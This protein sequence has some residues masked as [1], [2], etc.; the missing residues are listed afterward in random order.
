MAKTRNPLGH[1]SADRVLAY[2]MERS[3]RVLQ[4]CDLLEAL[5]DDLPKRSIPMWR[6]TKKQCALA[7]SSHFAL[8]VGVV[9]PMLLER[10]DGVADREDVILRVKADCTDL[11]HR[12]S[13]LEELFSDALS[14]STYRIKS[15]ALGFALRA[16]FEALRRHIGWETDVLWPLALRILT[17]EDLDNLADTIPDAVH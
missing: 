8:V 10:S 4:I 17:P 7:L 14:T 13:D 9:V 11:N 1:S 12:V 15:E 6:E 5:A 16:H 3:Q 2:L